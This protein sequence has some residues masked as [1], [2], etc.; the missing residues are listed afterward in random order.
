MDI[1]LVEHA[2]DDIDRDQRGGDQD[3]LVGQ[4]LLEDL[5][6]ALEAAMHRRRQAQMGDR[7]SIS[8]CAW[9]S[10]TPGARLN[11]IVAATNSPW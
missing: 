4:G 11:E 8:C 9:L 6:R 7:L 3:R 10:D 1:A 2:Q 5:G